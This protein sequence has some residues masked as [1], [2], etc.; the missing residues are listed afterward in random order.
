MVASVGLTPSSVALL[1]KTAGEVG[2]IVGPL[3]GVTLTTMGITGLSYGQLMLWAA[4]PFTI[5]WL[6]ATI[7]AVK[8]IQKKLGGIESYEITDDMVDINKMEITPTEKRTT[9]LFLIAFILLVAYGVIVGLGTNYAI[10]V[11]LVLA[12]VLI[13]SSRMEI[14]EALDTFVDGASK[15]TNMFLIFIFFEVMFVD[16][17][18]TRLNSSH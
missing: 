12:L 18:S 15:M 5:V 16:R 7:F 4:I 2:L 6:V 13:I 1:L 17:K 14:D 3:T 10:L 9:I 8:R 11:M